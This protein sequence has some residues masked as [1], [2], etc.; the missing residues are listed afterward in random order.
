MGSPTRLSTASSGESAMSASE[1]FMESPGH[2]PKKA[3][4]VSDIYEKDKENFQPLK[5]KSK[6][7][8]TDKRKRR[9]EFLVVSDENQIN[10]ALVN[11]HIRQQ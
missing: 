2:L 6:K 3:D 11:H 4:I 8:K 10:N 7:A 5:P 1:M 9:R